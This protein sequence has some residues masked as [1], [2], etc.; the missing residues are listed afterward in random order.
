MFA[1]LT[2]CLLFPSLPPSFIPTMPI[3]KKDWKYLNKKYKGDKVF[4]FY[5]EFE[6]ENWMKRK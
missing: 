3:Y 6:K 5:L 4:S 2:A 1:S